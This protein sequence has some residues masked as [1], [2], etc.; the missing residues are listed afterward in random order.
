MEDDADG[1]AKCYENGSDRLEMTVDQVECASHSGVPP[2]PVAVRPV[3]YV[4]RSH[5][6]RPLYIARPLVVLTPEFWAASTCTQ[7]YCHVQYTQCVHVF[8]DG[9]FCYPGLLHC[10]RTACTSYYQPAVDQCLAQQA[11]P[12]RCFLRCHA[13]RYPI[14]FSPEL[15]AH[16]ANQ[17]ATS[18]AA[19]IAFPTNEITLDDNVEYAVV[20][21]LYI[22]A[23]SAA[24]LQDADY[25]I[26]TAIANVS[27]ITTTYDV[28]RSNVSV[29]FQDIVINNSI[30]VLEVTVMIELP[31]LQATQRTD[32][33][34]QTM[35]VNEGGNSSSIA[36]LAAQLVEANVLFDPNQ[37]SVN[38][39][40]S[41]VSFASNED[42][43][44]NS[45][46]T[47]VAPSIPTIAIAAF[48]A[49]LFDR[50]ACC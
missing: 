14:T 5:Y 10:V 36:T 17:S 15:L 34:F 27:S 20:V 13:E 24:Q 8:G 33:L 31:S 16:A 38:E 7:S 26:A 37:L 9:C 4:H 23:M 50:V 25:E 45:G 44:G 39:V 3:T 43:P 11:Q 48:L 2:R 28:D 49:V 32:T 35:M 22:D 30:P 29:A 19:T 18:D 46:R 41:D 12:T 40:K 42:V 47:A 1:T 6:V 21:V